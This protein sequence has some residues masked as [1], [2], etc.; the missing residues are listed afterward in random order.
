M[1]SKNRWRYGYA[2]R[3]LRLKQRTVHLV[4]ALCLNNQVKRHVHFDHHATDPSACL[5]LVYTASS[6]TEHDSSCPIE[7]AC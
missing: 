4:S 5:L 2:N 7:D 6:I 1:Q 3:H